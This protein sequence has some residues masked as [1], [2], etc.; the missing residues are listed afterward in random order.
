MRNR[1][2]TIADIHCLDEERR[3]TMDNP[4]LDSLSERVWEA[5]HTFS[6][7]ARK[8]RVLIEKLP[9]P[10]SPQEYEELLAQR[11][12]E[13]QALENYLQLSNQLF[14]CLRVRSQKPNPEAP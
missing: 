1:G 4:R 13:T 10:T 5:F 2:G 14:V 8:M 6:D 9:F 11:L 3:Q 12:G 7:E